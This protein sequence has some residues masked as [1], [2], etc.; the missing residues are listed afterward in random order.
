MKRKSFAKVLI[1]LVMCGMLAGCGGSGPTDP[2]PKPEQ[3]AAEDKPAEKPEEKTAEVAQ[4]AEDAA[5]DKA[6]LDT[7]AA[8]KSLKEMSDELSWFLWVSMMKGSEYS[9]MEAGNLEIKLTD[10]EK[11]RAAAL[12]SKPDGVIDSSFVLDM[13]GLYEEKNAEYGSGGDAYHGQ[14]V[15][16]KDVEKNCLDLFGTKADW[17]SLPRGPVCDISD[18]VLYKNGDDQCALIIDREEETETDFENHEC[19]VT[20]EDG[21]YIGRINFFWG[22]WGELE[23]KPGYSNFEATYAIEPNAESKYGIVIKSISIKKT[24]D[25]PYEVSEEDESPSTASDGNLYGVF[26]KAFKNENDCDETLSALKDAGFND[27]PVVYTPDYAELNPEPYYVV[28]AGLFDTEQAA[29]EALEKAKAA[30]FSDA[31]VKYTGAY[32]GD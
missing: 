31:Y 28:T 27:C 3:E 23:Q 5:G 15:A 16:A 20:E 30:G 10:E 21:K 32:I 1:G 26:I 2:V 29:N 19:T 18:A 9:P 7:K 22:Y 11:I 25:D 12:T 24:A 14:S 17:D 6:E 4:Q 8:E 13:G